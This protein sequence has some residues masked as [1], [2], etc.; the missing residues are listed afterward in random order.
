MWPFK[1]KPQPKAPPRDERVWNEDW[2]VGD[3]AECCSD[4][5]SDLVKPWH[6]CKIGAR[7]TVTGFAEGE[8][9][10]G[11]LRYFLH[12]KGWPVAVSTTAFRKVRPVAREESEVA[13]RILK[14]PKV[15]PDRVRED[16]E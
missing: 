14:A 4:V 11:T 1:K 7:F 6:R 8:A 5:W 16:A 12:L 10:D 13:K 2:Q 3:T 9:D 15:G